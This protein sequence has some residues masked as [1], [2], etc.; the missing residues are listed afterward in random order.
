MADLTLDDFRTMA[1]HVGFDPNDPHLV[2]LLPDAQATLDRAA[3]LDAADLSGVEPLWSYPAPSTAA[4]HGDETQKP[5][6]DTGA[7]VWSRSGRAEAYS[8]SSDRPSGG[9]DRWTLS[10]L[11][12]AI[13]GK[14]ISPVDVT[15]AFIGRAEALEPTLNAFITLLPEEARAAAK[16]AE[17][18]IAAG[19]YRGPLHGI[20]VGLKDLF[21]TKGVRTTSGSKVTANFVPGE[22]ATVVARLQQAGSY[23]LGKTNMV[24]YAYGGAE[25]HELYG[26][27]RNPWGIEHVTGGSSSGSGAAVAAGQVPVALGTDT[28]GSVRA[29]AALCGLS[30][31]KPTYGLISRF[32]VSALSWSQDHVGPMAR[33]AEDCALIMNVLVG[34]DPRD[35]G[36]VNAPQVDYVAA[37][38]GEAR[39]LRVAVPANHIW[40][41]MHPETR[42]AFDAA[43]AQLGELGVEVERIEIPELDWVAAAQVAITQAEATAYHRER[44]PHQGPDYHPG[45]RRRIESGFFLPAH[46]YVQ[47]R[48]V[49]ALMEHRWAEIFGRFD[50]VAA[51]TVPM[52]APRFG[53]A[54]VETSEGEVTVRELVRITRLFNPNGL[55]A[56]SVPCGFSTEGL[57]I[58]LQLAGPRFADA[59]VL[60][61]AD[62]YQQAT[63]WHLRRP[64]L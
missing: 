4:P 39:G 21:W 23:A 13:R 8:Q 22:D 43:M 51:P 50:L 61:A 41:V 44:F 31:H 47:A 49:R 12:S 19:N 2:E 32:G 6:A 46:A 7:S 26:A 64:E 40:N 11:A 34:H 10:Q 36:S 18:E 25:H 42:A 38:N 16:Q 59:L 27:P 17:A 60:R 30:G 48:R 29:P 62:A 57:P 53:Q 5:G 1:A 52:P 58:G 28:A 9:L 45:V 37:L 14:Q 54:S 56:I 63:D 55:P 35:P 15:D 20:P 3:I 24:E 33:T